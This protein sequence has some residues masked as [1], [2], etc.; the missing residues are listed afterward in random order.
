MLDDA[1][2]VAQIAQ[3]LQRIQQAASVAGVKTDGGLVEEVEDAGESG[4]DLAGQ[5]DALGLS[6]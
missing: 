3:F 2:G 1:D 4:A 5:A 6:P